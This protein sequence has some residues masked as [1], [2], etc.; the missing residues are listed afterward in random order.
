VNYQKALKI[1]SQFVDAYNNTGNALKDMR[2]LSE[3]ET[4][5]RR[6]LKIDP[7]FS[8]AYSN[9]L[10][11]MNYDTQHDKQSIYAEHLRFAEH[12]QIK[13]SAESASYPNK[14]TI[15]RKLKV[16]Y[17]SPD[18]RRHSVNYFFE[19]V[20]ASHNHETFEI[21]CYS[22]VINPDKVTKQL[23][24]YADHWRSIVGISEESVA[25]TV[26]RDAI[27]I[28]VDLAGHTGYNRMPLF[29]RKPAPIQI[30][31]LGYPN[32]T[33]LSTIDYRIVDS[34]TDPIGLTD[35]YNT[36][37]LLR[38]PESFL[39]YQPDKESPKVGPLPVFEK[40]YITFG[41]FNYFTKTS[42]E[43]LSLWARI[44]QSVPDAHLFLK[45]KYFTDS[46]VYNSVIDLFMQHGID[47]ERIKTFAHTPSYR[48]HLNMYNDIDI[49]LDTFPYN[50][51]TTTCEAL[52]MG[53]PVI[54][55]QG[56]AHAS[57]VGTSLLSNIG[58]TELIATTQEEYVNIAV[59]LATDRERLCTLREGL[60]GRM[61]QSPLTDVKLFTSDLEICYK[62][63]WEKWC[64]AASQVNVNPR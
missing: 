21:F 3:A 13:F 31:W 32:T 17:V 64:K 54:T 50:G 42:P 51:T 40:R 26:R 44:L 22:D 59:D 19:P 7:D 14:K 15:N 58:L 61:A 16:G 34:Y 49:A 10:L 2:K 45:A 30:S 4:Y 9:L 11:N 38:M 43:I 48:E 52:W 63:V 25:E 1:D 28:L 60:R 57:R 8:P 55:L 20:L 23:Q 12:F 6:A 46:I 35:P 27:D 33:G 56:N 18:F 5:F 29:V 39:C 53:A 41:S 36:E 62:E 24:I 47:S 37:V